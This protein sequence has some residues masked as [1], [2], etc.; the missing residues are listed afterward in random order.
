[1]PEQ[2]VDM[3]TAKL[4]MGRA[5]SLGREY[6][7][8]LD[9]AEFGVYSAQSLCQF[10]HIF[11]NENMPIRRFW[12]FDSF[13]GVPREADWVEKGPEWY[14]GFCNSVEYYKDKC[15]KQEAGQFGQNGGINFIPQKWNDDESDLDNVI[16]VI[17]TNLRQCGEN[18][19]LVPGW[20]EDSLT[21]DVA[22]QMK[23]LVYVHVDVDLYI[24]AV[25]VLDFLLKYKLMAPGCLVRYDDWFG[26]SE[27]GGEQLAHAEM[28]EKYKVAWTWRDKGLFSFEGFA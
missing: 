14:E 27:K 8:E 21:E 28:T 5:H 13:F 19:T 4:Y 7:N 22:K 16:R 12:G 11:R 17:S 26:T 20:F 18:F 3:D 25:Q 15:D 24:S 6:S 1:M 9:F 2:S 23:P 10:M